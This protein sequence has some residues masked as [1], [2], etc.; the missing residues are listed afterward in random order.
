VINSRRTPLILSGLVVLALLQG[1]E[2]NPAMEQAEA[3]AESAPAPEQQPVAPTPPEP[4]AAP[5][6]SQADVNSAELRN[7]MALLQQQILQVKADTGALNQLSQQMLARQQAAEQRAASAANNSSNQPSA[8][9]GNLGNVQGQMAE[10]LEGIEGNY[11]LV[12]AYT[13]SG[14]WVLIRLDRFSGETW[15]ADQGRWN[16]LDEEEVPG[17]SEY[18][19]HMIRADRDAKG[20]VAARLDKRTGQTWWLNDRTWVRFD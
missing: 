15:L 14:A 7:Q 1:C 4:P 18:D 8:P 20:Y 2:T 5:A 10:L 16:M 11:R 17:V 3:A 12:S 13:G 9:S 19:V 6:P